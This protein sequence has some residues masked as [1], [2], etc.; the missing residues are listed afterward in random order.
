M[1]RDV[2]PDCGALRLPVR[3]TGCAE[4]AG[5]TRKASHLP[6]GSVASGTSPVAQPSDGRSMSQGTRR[7]VPGTFLKPQ[8]TRRKV[9]GTFLKPF[10]NPSRYILLFLLLRLCGWCILAGAE[11]TTP[12]LVEIINSIGMRFAP[13]PVGEFMMGSAASERGRNEDEHQHRV[14]ITVPFY[15]GVYEVT[16]TEYLR[17]MGRNPSCFSRTGKGGAKVRDVD[18]SRLPVEMVSWENATEFC[19]RLSELSEEKLAGRV[20]G[21]PTEAEWE[22][23]CR[24]GTRTVFHC[25]DSLSSAQANFDGS[26]PYGTAPKGVGLDR[27]TTVGSYE[28]NAWG[29]YDMHGNVW[30]FCQDWY[31]DN[32][33]ESAPAYDPT[34]PAR[35]FWRVSRGGAW[36]YKGANCRSAFRI[37]GPPPR[38]Q[39]GGFRVALVGRNARFSSPRERGEK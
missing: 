7:K 17:V 10:L 21:L 8:G 25:G 34:G 9:P 5:T 36:G 22:Y 13:I 31:S 35:G 30:E 11:E 6:F 2:V 14:A 37:G 19:R 39:Y 12:F 3:G 38:N 15:L 23:A 33:Y 28:P 20:Y 32:Y 27:T 1:A 16:Q 18:T 24:A 29:L 4:P 26:K